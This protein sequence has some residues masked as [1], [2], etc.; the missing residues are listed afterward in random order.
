MTT[1]NTPNQK[2][3]DQQKNSSGS[4]PQKTKVIPADEVREKASQTGQ[5]GQNGRG[6]SPSRPPRKEPNPVREWISD[7]LR[8][9]ILIAGI[10]IIVVVVVLVVKA[11]GGGS[12]NTGSTSG[13]AATSAVSA[14]ST[15][16]SETVKT[17]STVASSSA[18]Q[19]KLTEDTDTLLGVV[20]D[21]LTNLQ[22]SAD[23]QLVESY[24]DIKVYSYDGPTEGTYIA[25]ASFTYKY[26]EYDEQ[27]PGL[28]ELYVA[29]DDSG[30]LQVVTDVPDDVRTYMDSITEESDIAALISDVQ[31]QYDEVVSKNEDLKSYI[32]SLQ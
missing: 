7:N 23:N 6:T 12:K 24:S 3:G 17:D 18:S 30:T 29:P 26:K 32:D 8:Y 19:K 2:S 14:E 4:V 11:I 22:N 16:G 9:I 13:T 28:A 25:F 31:S 15:A 1:E 10:A 27:I 21:Y 20:T 5:S